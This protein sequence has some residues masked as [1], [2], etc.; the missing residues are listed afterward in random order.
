LAS[1]LS[2]SAC[3]VADADVAKSCGLDERQLDAAFAQT[4]DLT[5]GQKLQAGKCTFTRG[6]GE[7]RILVVLTKTNGW[8]FSE[9]AK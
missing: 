9:P 3:I 7:D 4:A 5:P 6:T 1:C 8:V 2:L